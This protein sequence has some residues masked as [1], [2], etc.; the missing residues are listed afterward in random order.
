[1]APV[2][3][4]NTW[5]VAQ[6]AIAPS[7]CAL[8]QG[9][10]TSVRSALPR[11]VDAPERLRRGRSK[12]GAARPSSNLPAEHGPCETLHPGR[13][14]PKAHDTNRTRDLAAKPPRECGWRPAR[15]PMRVRDPIARPRRRISRGPPPLTHGRQSEARACGPRPLHEYVG[16]GPE[17]DCT[18]R[19]RTVPRPGNLGAFRAPA[20][21]RCAGA[22]TP[23]A[24]QE[25]RCA[26]LF[27]SPCRARSARDLASRET[28]AQ[29]PRRHPARH[30]SSGS[31][32][33]Q[34]KGGA[35]L[36]AGPRSIS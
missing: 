31:T 6:K 1:M 32:P 23:R 24:Q 9:P 13:P 30:P 10:A 25:G 2:L 28:L 29:S 22:A 17:G 16:S 19:L 4:T 5:E 36:A 3:S 8:S 27:Q 34:K 18:V 21:S 26:P 12:R 15:I 33:P 14:S 35:R 11:G 7:A 20:R